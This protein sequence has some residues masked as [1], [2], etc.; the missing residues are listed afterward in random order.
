MS[1]EYLQKQFLGFLNTSPL[2]RNNEFGIQQ[3]EFPE[4]Q[5]ESFQPQPIPQNIRLGHQMEYLFKQLL[6]YSEAYQVLLHNL[7]IKQSNLTIG[8]IDFILNERATQKLIH[9]ELTYKFYIINTEI[10]TPLHRLIG[11][12][13]RDMFI[14][15]MKKIKNK[16]FALLHTEDGN[17]TLANHG[18]NTDQIEHQ[19]C[20]KA[21]L[22]TPYGTTVNIH[23]LNSGCIAGYWL[24][25]TDFNANNFKDYDFY[26]PNKSE[27]IITPHIEVTW[28]SHSQIL[29]AINL[30]MYE[31]NTPMIWMKKS[32]TVLEKFFVVWWK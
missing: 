6:Q 11:P 29:L 16:Q 4:L 31:E 19:C 22:Y 13:R 27:W 26:I 17:R 7:P 3:F 25:L 23:P 28:I 12:N 1:H 24:Q 20:Y 14:T 32:D 9:V 15:K 30:Y 5:L 18:I 8:E 10:T 2:W 21:Q